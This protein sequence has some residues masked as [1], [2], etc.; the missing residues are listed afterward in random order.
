MSETTTL[1]FDLSH[2]ERGQPFTLHAGF[3]KH[4]LIPHDVQ[5]RA[6]ARLGQPGLGPIPEHR[7]THYA[8]AVRLP[9]ECPILLRVTAPRRR[10]S[11]PLDR[12]VLTS[13]R[14][15][16][17]HRAAGL[18]RRRLAPLRSAGPVSAKLTAYG[19]TPPPPDDKLIDIGDSTRRWMRPSP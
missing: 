18:A 7:L 5:S 14:I 6:R 3:D 13:I 12:L 8:D 16:R 4:A 11:D 9:S 17:R 10:A 1:H 19:I 15:P 2:L